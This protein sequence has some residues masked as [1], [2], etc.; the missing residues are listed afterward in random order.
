LIEAYRFRQ[1]ETQVDSI[2]SSNPERA[3]RSVAA[4]A[5]RYSLGT[6]TIWRKIRAGELEAVK[7][8]HRTLI[9]EEAERTWLA[10]LPRVSP[11]V[12]A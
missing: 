4:F 1:S 3:A 10:S 6:A 11:K 12:A 9:T 8:G 7:V 5:T 2:N